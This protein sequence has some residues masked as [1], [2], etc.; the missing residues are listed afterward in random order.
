MGKWQERGEVRAVVVAAALALIA[1][2][3]LGAIEREVFDRL[4]TTIDFHGWSPDGRYVAYTLH[5]S[6]PRRCTEA[7]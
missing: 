5:R 2:P 6:S 3:A 1:L 7:C 4:G